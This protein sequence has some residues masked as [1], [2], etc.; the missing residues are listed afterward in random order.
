MVDED[1]AFLIQLVAAVTPAVQV[2]LQPEVRPEPVSQSQVPFVAVGREF[3]SERVAVMR[4]LVAENAMRVHVGS[5]AG[6]F[7]RHVG[8]GQKG[9]IHHAALPDELV[10]PPVVAP[11]AEIHVVDEPAA[12]QLRAGKEQRGQVEAQHGIVPVASRVLG[13]FVE[14]D[15]I[16]VGRIHFATG[17][18][19]GFV[20]AETHGR[21]DIRLSAV[22]GDVLAVVKRA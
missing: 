6:V 4:V 10:S 8:V 12:V 21:G 19:H 22:N 14:I 5:D 1:V 11:A 3:E 17:I 2:E 18:H 7:Q 9:G 15:G 13:G 16:Q 20:H